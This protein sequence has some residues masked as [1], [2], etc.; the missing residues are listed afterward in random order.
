MPELGQMR[1]LARYNAARMHVALQ[2]HDIWEWL[3]AFESTLALSQACSTQPFA[4]ASLVGGAIDGVA[5]RQLNIL[6]ASKPDIQTLDAVERAMNRQLRNDSS[7]WIK[8]ERAMGLD[9]IAWAF[10]DADNVRYGRASK[11]LYAQTGV[12][13]SMLK[14]GWRIGTYA[15]N[16]AEYN[17]LADRKLA[18]FSLPPYGRIRQRT[19]YTGQLV[20]VERLLANAWDGVVRSDAQRRLNRA[21]TV[22]M[23]ALERYRIY[24]GDYPQVLE[25][26][27]PGYLAELP[28][29]P[30]AATATPL[31][32]RRVDPQDDPECR[33]YL[34]Y[35]VGGDATDNGG[36]MKNGERDF[37]SLNSPDTKL[38]AVDFVLNTF[39]W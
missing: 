11:N 18:T 10:A 26:L 5:M 36:F 20:L 24:T 25:Q 19:L 17:A 6:L 37:G 12:E 1:G 35:T 27:V 29:D 14:D 39:K 23:I 28:L 8:G 7:V 21:A 3:R 34:L 31:A 32:Y 38:P 4:I 33:S 9:A 2:N 30:W 15:E 13:Q 16:I 22:T